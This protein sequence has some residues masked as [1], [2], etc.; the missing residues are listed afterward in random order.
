MDAATVAAAV[1]GE[2]P[3]RLKSCGRA[4]YAMV[5]AILDDN[6]QEL[7]AGSVG[8]IAVRGRTVRPYLLQHAQTP[9]HTSAAWHRTGDIG[10]KDGDGYVYIVDRRHDVVI[11]GGHNVYTT[12]VEG[13][14][15]ELPGVKACAVFG[16]PNELL[17]EALHAVVVAQDGRPLTA[18]EVL[19]HC[20]AGL[21]RVRTPFS[22]E[23][24]SSL[25]QTAAGKIAK[26]TLR[27]EHWRDNETRVV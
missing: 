11:T 13:R 20:L 3:E 2:K 23:F 16:V 8:E 17:G 21:G 22:V 26:T 7:P 4:A 24:R 10:Y 1:A 19:K 12:E 25:P 14:I 18:A 9:R 15:M 27:A 5:V 6:D